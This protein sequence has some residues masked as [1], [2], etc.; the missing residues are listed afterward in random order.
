MCILRTQRMASSDNHEASTKLPKPTIL[1]VGFLSS[2]TPQLQ[3]IEAEQVGQNRSSS[4]YQPAMALAN[5]YATHQDSDDNFAASIS[6]IKLDLKPS[7]LAQSRPRPPCR[8]WL[9]S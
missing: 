7:F 2:V 8:P 3:A 4:Y 1:S 9:A 6:D 5:M